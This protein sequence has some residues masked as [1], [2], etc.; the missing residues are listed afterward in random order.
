MGAVISSVLGGG[1]AD[2]GS[3]SSSSEPSRVQAFHSS[4]RWQLH[5]NELKNSSKLMV[6]DFSATWCGPCKFMEP[7]FN[8][9][10]N[11][12]TDVDFVKIDVDE[13]SSVAQQFGVDA[14]PTFVFVKEGKE[15]DRLVGATRDD[16]KRRSRITVA[17]PKL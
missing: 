3:S 2:N 14:M 12:F 15:V 6:I 13:L 7:I 5:F 17:L 9:L 8:H 16:L 10:S 11:K 1:P 4:E